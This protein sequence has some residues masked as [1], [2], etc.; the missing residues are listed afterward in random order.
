MTRAETT[1]QADTSAVPSSSA[2]GSAAEKQTSRLPR[3]TLS[4][5]VVAAVLAS[6]LVLPAFIGNAAWPPALVFALAAAAVQLVRERRAPL[7]PPLMVGFI[8]VYAAAAIHGGALSGSDAARYFLRPLAALALAAIAT[9]AAQ[10]TRA[11]WL[12]FLFA[13]VQVPVTAGQAIAN[14]VQFGRNTTHHADAVTGT[15]GSSQ[16]GTVTLV[17]T[18]TAILVV[19]AWLIGAVRPK[20]AG[21]VAAALLSVGIFS[22]TRALIGFVVVGAAALV[23]VGATQVAWRRP[24]RR[25][26]VATSAAALL[27]LPVVY[28]AIRALYPDA[29][30]GAFG[31]QAASVLVPTRGD[32]AL[33]E[34]ER[35][36]RFG[37]VQ[38]LPGRL[39]QMRLAVRLSAEDGPLTALLGRGPGSAALQ[40]GYSRPAD[41][42]RPQRTGF[43]W[44]G[45]LLTE[46]GWLGLAAFFALLVWLAFLG[47][48]VWGHAVADADRALGAALVGVA[49]LTAVGA[50]YTPVLDVRGYSAVFWILV[51]LGIAAAREL[52]ERT[53]REVRASPTA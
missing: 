15:L 53:T 45:K 13:A 2:N 9:T 41:V 39:A 47:R 40:P 42:P 25:M 10:R 12:L 46:T 4:D 7:L 38:L 31:S 37:G 22:S 36:A 5:V 43:T 14:V 17:A 19:S 44:I 8:A 51:G 23:V 35:L 11:L 29:W 6:A 18:G 48:R 26:L 20:V 49:A 28:G 33:S 21:P 1:S 34:A 52:P 24:P 50:A 32:A 16:A 27:S 3:P 30:R